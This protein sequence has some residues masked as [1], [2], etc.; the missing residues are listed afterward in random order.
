[1]LSKNIFST[2]HLQTTTSE[3]LQKDIDKFIDCQANES[4]K[5]THICKK[6]SKAWNREKRTQMPVT[7]GLAA[8]IRVKAVGC[9]CRGAPSL[10]FGGIL[11]A[12][13]SE[14]V[15]T[16]GATQKNLEL[17]LLPNSLD[18]HQTQNNKMKFW[19][20]YSLEGELTH[21]VDKAKIV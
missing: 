5:K 14:K 19:T 18:S 4:T 20:F 16:T 1:M 21:R 2:E 9:F 11:N 12:T 6:K 3:F 17:P 8:L 13:L 15:S 7:E 10:M